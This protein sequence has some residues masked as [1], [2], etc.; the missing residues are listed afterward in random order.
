MTVPNPWLRVLL[1]ARGVIEATADSGL[2]TVTGFDKAPGNAYVLLAPVGLMPRLTDIP[3]LDGDADWH[4]RQ[5]ETLLHAQ[6]SNVIATYSPGG[7]VW[8]VPGWASPTGRARTVIGENLDEPIQRGVRR[9]LRWLD[10]AWLGSR[11]SHPDVDLE[12]ILAWVDEVIA[13][14]QADP[15][16]TLRFGYGS[17]LG[18]MVAEVQ[19]ER[20]PHQEIWWPGHSG[21]T[22]RW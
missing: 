8:C 3:A 1:V 16:A 14:V 11:R 6:A 12:L 17:P 21:L 22:C 7:G 19:G 13:A 5:S 9:W 10:R 15:T 20:G 4:R 2:L 18:W